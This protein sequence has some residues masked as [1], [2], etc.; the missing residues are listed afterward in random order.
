MTFFDMGI[1]SE[2][3]ALSINQ[4]HQFCFVLLDLTFSD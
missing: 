2:N 1:N 3:E 4:R